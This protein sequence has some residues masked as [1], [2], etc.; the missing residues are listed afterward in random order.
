MANT[1]LRD[2]LVAAD[3][4]Y[5]V[6]VDDE[7]LDQLTGYTGCTYASPPQ[8]AAQALDLVRALLAC[9]HARLR[10]EDSPWWRA[11]AGGRRTIRVHRARAD[12]GQAWARD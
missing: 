4:L 2:T 6:E 5:V 3:P 9:P 12:G 7:C 11:I 8:P 1:S 10:V